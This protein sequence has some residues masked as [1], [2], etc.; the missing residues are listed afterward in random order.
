M[1]I[2]TSKNNQELMDEEQ[3]HEIFLML[4]N[5]LE[6]KK[7]E[8]IIPALMFLLLASAEHVG[9]PPDRLLGY[10]MSALSKCASKTDDASVH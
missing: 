3:S 6:G 4:S 8:H 7:I 1:K 5:T 10:F 9:M 2:D